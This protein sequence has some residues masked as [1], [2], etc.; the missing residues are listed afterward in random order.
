VINW[1]RILK[2]LKEVA[3][4]LSTYLL[5]PNVKL[6]NRDRSTSKK[7]MSDTS[8]RRDPSAFEYVLPFQEIATLKI[9]N[10]VKT[11]KKEK[12]CVRRSRSG[13]STS[14]YYSF[15]QTL[16]PFIQH[17]K[18]VA[19]DGNCGFRRVAGLLGMGEDNW[20]QIMMD[21]SNEL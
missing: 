11:K 7:K 2:K 19:A 13:S 1:V 16:R 15:L 12:L 6:N 17:I 14:F 10:M 18:D 20:V 3:N 21:L 5:E 9:S 4:L 8:T